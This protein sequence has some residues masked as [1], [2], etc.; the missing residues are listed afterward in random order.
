[1]YDDVVVGIV[2][3][4]DGNMNPSEAMHAWNDANPSYQGDSGEEAIFILK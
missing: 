3:N 2:V 1:M 4:Q